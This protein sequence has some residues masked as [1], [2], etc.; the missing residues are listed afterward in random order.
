MPIVRNETNRRMS[1]VVK[2]GSTIYLAGQLAY[3][4]QGANPDAQM[5]E[6]LDRIDR[7]LAEF[8]ADKRSLVSATVWLDDISDYDA[9][10]AVWDSWVPESYAPARAC[11][12][13][14]L[15][16][17]GFK[18]EVSAIAYVGD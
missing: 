10:N 13:A 6:I 5:R 2:A 8:G 17:T 1:Q 16:M 3:K 18:V 14:K 7:F 11:V 15:A 4:N 12:E 9:I